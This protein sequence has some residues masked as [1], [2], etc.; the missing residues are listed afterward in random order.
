MTGREPSPDKLSIN[1]FQ[2]DESTKIIIS[3]TKDEERIKSVITKN[4]TIAHFNKDIY[5][6]CEFRDKYPTKEQ[7]KPY[8]VRIS[9]KATIASEQRMLIKNNIK[10]NT[11]KRAAIEST[12]SALER[13]HGIDKLRIR[14]L[15]KCNVVAGLKITTHN[16]KRFAKIYAE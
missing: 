3:Y 9:L 10:K 16:F 15:S 12:N 7:K 1:E 6:C 14:G 13:A 11:S 2:F 8:V 4:D 5:S